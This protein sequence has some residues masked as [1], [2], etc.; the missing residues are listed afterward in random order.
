MNAPKKKSRFKLVKE[1]FLQSG[2]PFEFEVGKILDEKGFFVYGEFPYERKNEKGDDTE[3]SSDIH[4]GYCCAEKVNNFALDLLIECKYC[5]EGINWFFI[6][7]LNDMSGGIPVHPI[8]TF[9]AFE[10]SFSENPIS[11][12][13]DVCYKG[14]EISENEKN[15]KKIEQA[16]NQIAY[17]I[18]NLVLKLLRRQFVRT[19]DSNHGLPVYPNLIAG[20]TLTGINQH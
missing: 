6:P 8:D 11:T 9:S 15:N 3:F 18:P 17:A 4:A 2:I 12:I 14:I 5:H 13:R 1:L 20:M 7:H 10:V 16:F 19:T